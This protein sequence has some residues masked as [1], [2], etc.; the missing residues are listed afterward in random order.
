MSW[1]NLSRRKLRTG[2]T[3]SGIVVGI[4]MTFVF[5]SLVSGMDVQAAQLIQRL[6][7]ADITIYNATRLG[8][9]QIIAGAINTLDA[10]LLTT[11]QEVDGVYVTSPQLTFVGS[12]NRT[13][14]FINGIDATSYEIVTGGLN[15]I[16]GTGL[17]EGA[18]DAVVLGKTI[19]DTLEVHVG[20]HVTLN[21]LSTF[22]VIGIYE[23][24]NALQDRGGYVTLAEAQ[25]LSMQPG[26]ITSIL[27]KV[28]DPNDV[29]AVQTALTSLLSGIRLVVPTVVLQQVSTVL[30][31]IRLFLFSIGLV[32]LIAGS[33]GVINTMMT[34][35]SERTRE[36]GTLKAIGAKDGQILAI[37]V[38]EAL[39][40]G[41]IGGAT[42]VGI[43]VLLTVALPL[44][45]GRLAGVSLPGLGSG[46]GRLLTG[47]SITPAFLPL[48]VL[49]CFSLGLV[50][51]VIAGLY[52]SGRAARMHPVEALRHV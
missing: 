5:L 1:K 2:L 12:I 51:G 7:G 38:S 43:G 35:I 16:E 44:L 34:S 8:R 30:N 45:T 26:A 3:V 13:R 24:G 11:V 6:G 47:V 48:N 17:A 52:P 39:L 41:V 25:D 49:L 10:S 42:G 36:I 4:A 33:F 22:E 31:T 32:A 20:S 28:T 9:E 14:A 40:L 27:L 21:D 15:V 46:V 37:F 23:T 19:A 29:D 50:V 18:Q